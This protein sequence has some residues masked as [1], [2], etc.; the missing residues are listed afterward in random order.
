MF[1]VV[2]PDTDGREIRAISAVDL[3]AQLSILEIRSFHKPIIEQSDLIRM[4]IRTTEGRDRW[5]DWDGPAP[6]DPATLPEHCR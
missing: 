1:A 2:E 4:K 3:A 5:I 6:P